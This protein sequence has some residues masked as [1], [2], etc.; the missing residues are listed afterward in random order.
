MEKT[1]SVL[2]SEQSAATGGSIFS[3]KILLDALRPE[4]DIRPLLMKDVD[5]FHLFPHKTYQPTILGLRALERQL[6]CRLL[7]RGPNFL[8]RQ[9]LLRISRLTWYSLML[10]RSMSRAIRQRLPDIL[11][12]NNGPT[13]NY[14]ELQAAI[15]YNIPF[16][17][18]MRSF[19]PVP[20]YALYTLRKA[21]YWIAVSKAVRQFYIKQGINGELIEVIPNG[22]DLER[23]RPRWK[24]HDTMAGARV[25]IV[26]AGRLIHWKGFS[27]LL[28]VVHQ[29]RI[30]KL[31]N[32]FRL[33]IF[34]E[35]PQ[36]R[37]LVMKVHQLGL[38]EIVRIAGPVAHME[39]E[40]AD[41]D[42]AIVPSIRPDPFPRTCI[43]AMAAGLPV[44]GTN[45]GGIPEA[46]VDGETGFL[47]EPGSTMDT[48]MNLRLLVDRY[49]LRIR[50]G[51][52]ARSRAAELYAS[53]Q[54]A[55][56]V[57][58]VYRRLLESMLLE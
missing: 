42:I 29:L 3:M 55:D 4:W 48:A 37:D 14:A 20:T 10:R 40:L 47:V 33:D 39:E 19:A 32:P 26:A 58:T 30:L 54:Y 35:G 22:V 6:L 12:G 49:D 11:H 43:E 52:A 28:D 2:I 27:W 15:S 50:M 57:A 36:M 24:Q 34:G 56:A 45:I 18:H 1:A 8:G 41:A 25:K 31:Q 17:G 51:K 9:Y 7:L 38:E 23:F 44:I 5:F 16:V 53:R 46:I 13:W 21:R